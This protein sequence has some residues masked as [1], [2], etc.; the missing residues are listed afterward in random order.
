MALIV[1]VLALLTINLEMI[2]AVD[3]PELPYGDPCH[4]RV[5]ADADDA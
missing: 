3:P 1:I 4:E 2:K 5:D